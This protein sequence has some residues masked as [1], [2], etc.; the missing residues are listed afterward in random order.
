MSSLNRID[1]LIAE[2]CS[3]GVPFKKLSE[4]AK[5][6][7]GDRGK[8]YPS[9]TDMV[10][11]G[12][13]FVNA[14]DVDGL[15]DT[16]NC[17]KI[18]LEK[19]Q[20]LGGAKLRKNDILYCLR[21]S[22]GKNGI[23]EQNEGT[24]ASSLVAIR[25]DDENTDYKY[26]YYLLNSGMERQQRYK[27]DTGA[28]QPNLSA[29]SVKDY[30]FPFPPIEIQQEIVHILDKFCELGKSLTEELSARKKQYESYR[31]KLFELGDNVPEYKM[32]DVLTFLNGRAYKQEEL[33][34]KGKYPVLRVGNFYTNDS[35]YYS[36]LELPEDKYCDAG[37]L[38]YS[39]AA[40]LGPKIWDG[41]KCIFHY[42]I[43]KILFDEERIDK[44]YLYYYLQY[45]LSNIS[46][47]TT[48]STMIH[49]SMSSMKDRI[50][51]IPSIE[52]QKEI[53]AILDNF[54]ILCNDIKKGLPAEIN[55]R[56]KQYEYY[57][58][59]LLTFERVEV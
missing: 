24:V 40:T 25:V 36:D 56:K 3:T 35:W 23:Y 14:G 4:V 15:V 30:E 1:E 7:N 50:I 46:K 9:G 27:S 6:Y 31:D 51:K 5:F 57:K 53:V 55:A 16:I 59:K 12:V 42:H 52:K 37:D 58:E 49:V 47:S 8:N 20:S 26:V 29:Q 54:E 39:W 43:W 33:L 17:K 21:G 2:K 10:E 38:L 41:E 13:P 48:A 32:G 45:D 34:G 11:E 19:Y 18:T 28:A 22:T 44:R